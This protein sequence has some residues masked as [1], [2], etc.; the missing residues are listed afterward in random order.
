MKVYS[1]QENKMYFSSKKNNR[2]LL[3]QS[4]LI[5]KRKRIHRSTKSCSSL[6]IHTYRACMYLCVCVNIYISRERERG[7]DGQSGRETLLRAF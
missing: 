1:S 3:G 7:R 6:S 4:N 5:V 2:H